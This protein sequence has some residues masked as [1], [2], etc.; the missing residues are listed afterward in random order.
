M[1]VRSYAAFSARAALKPHAF[2]PEPL[3]DDDVELRVTHSALCHS[4][5]HVIDNDWG[6][7]RYPLVPG[8]EIAGTVTRA[9]TAVTHLKAGDRAGVGWQSGSCGRCAFCLRGEENFC[10]GEI[11]TCVGR[12]G[13]F[14]DA[15]RVNARFAF[16]LPSALSS[17][18]AAPLLCAGVTVYSPMRVFGVTAGR[19]VGVIG[20]GALGHL[21]VQF[22]AKRGCEVAVISSSP[23]KRADALELGARHFLSFGEAVEGFRDRFDFLLAT[24]PADLNWTHAIPLLAVDGKLCFVGYPPKPLRI[25]VHLLTHARRSVCG[26]PIGGSR[27]IKEM[28]DFA[29]TNGVRPRVERMPLSRVNDGIARV[30][31]NRARYIVVFE[32]DFEEAGR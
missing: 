15:V 8:H 6:G 25:P 18:E 12:P 5:I 7:S 22:A 24:A 31:A 16:P 11:A 3:R 20:F 9:G 17:A 13:G 21:A 2:D 26:S 27:D 1:P 4:D 28:L 32:N 10:D 19:T 29:A 14:A 30:R 23:D